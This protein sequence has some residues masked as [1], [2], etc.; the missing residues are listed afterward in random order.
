MKI[1][2]VFSVNNPE[3]YSCELQDEV[4]HQSIFAAQQAHHET[5]ERNL[6][7]DSQ[8]TIITAAVK[9]V[10]ESRRG[11]NPVNMKFSVDKNVCIVSIYQKNVVNA[12]YALTIILK[13]HVYIVNVRVIVF[14]VNLY[15]VYEINAF[16]K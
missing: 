5:V 9:N 3:I 10:R 12:T 2:R 14:N 11:E 7:E 1:A 13:K 8:M 15:R 6:H 16:L 4:Y